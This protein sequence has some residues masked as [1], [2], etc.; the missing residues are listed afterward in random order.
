M[1]RLSH[2]GDLAP[3]ARDHRGVNGS[4]GQEGDPRRGTGVEHGLV[5]A[6]ENAVAVLPLPYRCAVSISVTPSSTARRPSTQ[7]DHK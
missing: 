6:I 7:D 1:H 2:G 4:P 5:L 3:R